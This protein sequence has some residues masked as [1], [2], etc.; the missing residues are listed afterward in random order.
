MITAILQHHEREQGQGYPAG[1]SEGD[2]HDY[3]LIVGIADTYEAMTH[4]RPYK[5][6]SPP[7]IAIVNIINSGKELFPN[8]A[9]KALVSRI[10]L[11]PVGTWVELN[12]GEICKV[13]KI[14]PDSP[15]RPV[16]SI[17][18]DKDKNEFRDIKVVDLMKIPSLYIKQTTDGFGL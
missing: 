2:I 6:K 13:I 18:K 3:A 7:N 15:L 4:S 16:I 8:R 14:N 9:I 10:G 17:L 1:L 12:T 11:Y 5:E